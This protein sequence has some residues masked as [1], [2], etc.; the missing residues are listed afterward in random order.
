MELWHSASIAEITC[1][2]IY[3]VLNTQDWGLDH[4]GLS[5]ISTIFRAKRSIAV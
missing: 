1:R 2:A 3:S 4:H 5:I